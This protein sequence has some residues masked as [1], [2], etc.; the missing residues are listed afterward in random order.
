MLESEVEER[1]GFVDS[2]VTHDEV[3]SSRQNLEK[4]VRRITDAV[5]RSCRRVAK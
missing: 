2:Y 1:E 5:R 3:H 4:K